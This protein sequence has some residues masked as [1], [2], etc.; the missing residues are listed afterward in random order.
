MIIYF[1]NRNMDVV[2]MASSALPR[3]MTIYDDTLREDTETATKTLSFFLAYPAEKAEEAMSVTE[4]GNYI[5]YRTDDRTH[6]F[7]IIDSDVDTENLSIEIYAEDGGLDL[8]N[9]SF[10]ASDDGV[11]RNL[12][13]WLLLFSG[14]AGFDIGVCEV[15]DST[16]R[17][18]NFGDAGTAS[19]RLQTVAE[20]F[21]V[22]LDFSFEFANFEVSRKYISA[23]LR[24]G[25]DNGTILRNGIEISSIRI[26]RSVANLVTALRPLGDEDTDITDSVYDDGDIYT[27]AGSGIL[28]CRSAI[29]KFGRPVKG[30]GINRAVTGAFKY[31]TTSAGTLL[32]A[33][34]AYLKKYSEPEINYEC[35]LISAPFSAGDTVRI[36]DNANGIYDTL[37]VL[38]V[39]RCECRNKY[40]A[41]FGIHKIGD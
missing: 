13:T 38:S 39:E 14:G 11:A 9:D 41:T 1:L 21:G 19:E 27:V 24:K 25:S 17:A 35:T 37:R 8:L 33:A 31:D 23:Y 32:S 18:I 2:S 7:T 26:R 22:E 12:R 5:I 3:T 4:Q 40:S 29:R 36:S 34:V 16:T 30:S 20:E 15:G 28:Y 10:P 6:F